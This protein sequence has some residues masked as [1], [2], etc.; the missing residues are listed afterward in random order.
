MTV[1]AGAVWAPAA[2]LVMLGAARAAEPC[3]A[4]AAR[5]GL[6]TP[7]P[8][9]GPDAEATELNAA[10]KTLYRQGRWEEARARYRAAAAADPEFLA[11]R[12][13]VACSFVRQDQ[14]RQAA[15]EVLALISRAYVPWAREVLEAAD[16]G[17]LKVRPEMTEIQRAMDDAAAR[18]GSDLEDGVLF[19]ARQRAP[20]RVPDQG[21]GVFIL[22]P[23]QEV[24]AF[25]PR[26]ARYRP[27]TAEDGHVLLLARAPDGRR[28]AYVTA[29]KLVRGAGAP[30]LRGVALHALTVATMV[31]DPPARI[32]GDVTSLEI[33][34]AADPAAFAVRVRG[35]KTNGAFELGGG[36]L[37][38][39]PDGGRR[40]PGL[41]L[42][43]GRGAGPARPQRL[44][45]SCALVA[46]DAPGADGAR[47]VLLGGPG[48]K[49]AA[50]K[51]GAGAGLVGLPIP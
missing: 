31:A 17:A 22:N 2:L 3:L 1:L 28:I 34:A 10:G 7:D 19:I 14:F 29:D 25:S 18:W 5:P 6:G 15:D 13:N 47:R 40:G 39:M 37:R 20:L 42:L 46:R 24:W 16:L 32:E 33:G 30:A 36:I 48:Q 23:H 27:L 9:R 21:A 50:L 11:P 38:P 26:T 8:F 35:D 51:S 45:G 12:L 43:T 41:G 4:P 44:P 49:A